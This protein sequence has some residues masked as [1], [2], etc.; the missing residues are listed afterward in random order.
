MMIYNFRYPIVL[1]LFSFI[2]LLAA[3]LLKTMHL[4]GGTL[5]SW[6]MI[7]CQVISIVWLMSMSLKFK[8]PVLLFLAGFILFLM[9][10]A[11]KIMHWPN[12]QFI[13]TSM[14]IVQMSAVIWLIV[15]IL[16]HEKSS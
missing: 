8:Y 15:V 14:L 13:I 11:F 12:A 6:I 3:M 5:I 16:R 7:I 2:L 4:P 10:L 9:G 1:F